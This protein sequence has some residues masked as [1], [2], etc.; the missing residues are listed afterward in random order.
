MLLSVAI[1]AGDAYAMGTAT[2]TF[3]HWF[4]ALIALPAI[5]YAG[6]PFFGSAWRALRA[7]HTNMDV[8]ISLGVILAPAMS[9]AETVRGGRARLFRQRRDPAVLPADRPLPRPARAGAAPGR[10]RERLLALTA[11]AVDAGRC[12]TAPPAASGRTGRGRA[13]RP[14]RARASGSVSTARVTDGAGELDTSLITGETVPQRVARATGCSPAR[15]IS[16]R[17]LRLR[18]ARGRRRHA[19][20]RDRAADGAGR[21][22]PRRASWRSPTG[23][24][25][26]TRRSSTAWRC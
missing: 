13:G 17:P 9:L 25:A 12:R 14:G 7:G 3:L 11:S 4:Q 22:A 6:R 19:A 8:P 23:W 16:A 18:V 5:A 21:A 24:R 10:R 15:S 20:G 2:R 26:P 1:W